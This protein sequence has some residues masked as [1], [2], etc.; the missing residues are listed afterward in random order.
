[1]VERTSKPVQGFTLDRL[2]GFSDGVLAI[3]ITLLVLGIDIPEGHN[4]SEQGLAAFLWRLKVDVIM[5]AASFWLIAA[6]W[7]QHHTVFQYLRYCNRTVMWLNILFLFPLT[8]MPFLTKLKVVYRADEEVV[9]LFGSAFVASGLILVG[10]WRYV[11]SRPELLEHPGL[12]PSVVGSMT[13]RILMGPLISLVA[14]GVTFLYYPLGT[15]VFCTIPIFYL[16]H[17]LIDSGWKKRDES[18]A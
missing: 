12:D 10:I 3:V 4:F 13:R 17:P 2:K 1:M 16:S 6:Y 11:I 5:Y 8:L 15:I 14:V 7:V 9:P 18:S